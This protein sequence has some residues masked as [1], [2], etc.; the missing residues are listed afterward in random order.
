MR[1]SY[2]APIMWLWHYLGV[3]SRVILCG[4]LMGGVVQQM[5][6]AGKGL[7]TQLPEP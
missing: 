5:K 2:L 7:M 3:S 6:A 4:S 1:P